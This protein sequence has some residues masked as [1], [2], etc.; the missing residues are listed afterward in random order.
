MFRYYIIIIVS[1]ALLIFG[2]NALLVIPISELSLGYLSVFLTLAALEAFAV[3]AIAALAVRYIIPQRF[4]NP[5]A[6][7]FRCLRAEKR[8]YTKL[9]IRKWKDKIPETGGLLVG[10]QKKKVTALHDNAYIYKFMQ[11]TCYAELMHLISMPLGFITLALCPHPLRLT[12]ALPV[13][14]VNAFLQLLP[15]MVQRFIRPQ[16]LRVYNANSKRNKQ[17][18]S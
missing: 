17:Q 8:V 10:F 14:A 5:F 12:V 7:R 3:D 6:K 11:E 15:V 1:A 16:L 18:K 13:A 4:Y 2:C 9:G